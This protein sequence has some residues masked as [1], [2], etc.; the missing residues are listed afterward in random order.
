[1]TSLHH[2]IKKWGGIA[3]FALII[4][5]PFRIYAQDSINRVSNVPITKVFYKLGNHF[6]G[7][8]TYHY[9]LN[10]LLAG[11][12]T[13][14]IVNTGIDWKWHRTSIDHGWMRETGFISV[15]AG[16]IV[17][18]TVPSALYLY[19]LLDKNSDIQVTGLA[20]GQA[21]LL[22]VGISSMI[23]VFTGRVSPDN[24][25]SLNDYSK[26]FRFGVL[27]GGILEG[28]PS[29]HTTVA[30]AMATTLIELYP[31][32]LAIKIGAL[33]YASLIGLG[34]STNVHW[35]SDVVAGALIGYS[36]GKAVGA[37]YRNLMSSTPKEKAYHFYVTPT[38]VC[39]NY[40]F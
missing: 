5:L 7:S 19:G 2:F 1:M 11:V 17:A 38:G 9:G 29:S 35:S 4:F 21:A 3:S 20:L 16:P 8:F 22:G 14:A 27:R 23:K 6:V 34:V 28:W 25:T 30:F 15:H 12:S 39:F 26:N 24:L 18:Y 31:D 32:N 40:R 36:I 37:G 33:T 13:Y 10:Y